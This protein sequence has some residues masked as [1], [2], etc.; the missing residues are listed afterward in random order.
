MRVLVSPLAYDVR[1]IT[2]AESS[3]RIVAGFCRVENGDIAVDMAMSPDAQ[4]ATLVHELIHAMFYAGNLPSEEL[5]E[6]QV[7]CGLEMP[8]LRLLRD[9]PALIQALVKSKPLPL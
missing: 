7:C 6:E 1:A 5:T 2:P 3:L 4:A 8:L 9:N